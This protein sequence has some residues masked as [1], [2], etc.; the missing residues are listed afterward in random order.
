M[1]TRPGT[2]REPCWVGVSAEPGLA[3]Q[4]S[5]QACCLLLPLSE[6]RLAPVFILCLQMYKKKGRRGCG[7]GRGEE[8]K[9]RGSGG[10]KN[11]LHAEAITVDARH[12]TFLKSHS[13]YHA[14]SEP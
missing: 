7:W 9:H 4:A 14:K 8:A 6:E 3:A 5:G 10:N 11:A 2:E 1:A 13:M 12:Y